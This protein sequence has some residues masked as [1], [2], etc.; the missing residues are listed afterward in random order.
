MLIRKSSLKSGTGVRGIVAAG[1]ALCGLAGSAWGQEAARTP[2]VERA[3]SSARGL[4]AAFNY[5]SRTIAPSVVHVSPM[6][7]VRRQMNWFEPPQTQL[8]ELGA[9]SGIIMSADGYILT[10][11]HVIAGAERVRV[12]LP[13]GREMEGKIVG[14][15]PATDLGVVKVD[16]SGLTPA[17][18][19]DADALEVGEWVLAVGSPFGEYDNTVTAGIVSAKNR[20][21]LKQL[22]SERFEDFIQT[23]AAINPGNSGGP[24]VDI[25]GR[26]VGIN[27]QIA[28]RAGQS[29]GV[30]FS[31][32]ATI[33]RPVM[34]SIIKT[35]RAQRGW[36]GIGPLQA[37]GVDVTRD[38]GI[39]IGMVQPGSPA[40]RAGIRKGD[41]VRKIGGRAADSWTRVNNA[42]IFSMPGSSVD[43]DIVRDGKPQTVSARIEDRAD[44]IASTLGGKAYKRFGFAVQ[45]LTPEI[46]R[47]QG[48][49]GDAEGV[50][51]TQVDAL[52]PAA[53]GQ[54]PLRVN[55]IIVQ[56][57]RTTVTDAP[58]FDRTIDALRRDTIRL[59][60]IR[61]EQRGFIEIAAQ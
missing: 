16:G 21:N 33:A 58:E 17:K 11:N 25:E 24:L 1:L 27:S 55:D 14:A 20:T 47:Q 57:N 52:G 30:G 29:A 37:K 10:N 15:D 44:G 28:T 5:A 18:W 7:R 54:V 50:I 56:V 9:G 4:S 49:D 26:V 35:G 34:E 61:G 45:S 8:L 42:V 53:Q 12:K 46:L 40:E 48:Y 32:P 6:A 13:D 38:G 41:V 59:G 51:V 60:V 39:V 22:T 36:L 3:I 2:E 19:G 43:I 23:D 31:I